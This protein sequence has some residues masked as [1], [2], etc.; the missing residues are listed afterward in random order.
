MKNF[1]E[2]KEQKPVKPLPSRSNRWWVM[3]LQLSVVFLRT[4]QSMRP[5]EMILQYH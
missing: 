5:T 3:N 4:G 2:E 1:T